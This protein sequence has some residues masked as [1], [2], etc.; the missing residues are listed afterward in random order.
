[1]ILIPV[2]ILILFLFP[3]AVTAIM[4][5]W[6][7]TRRTLELQEVASHLSSAIQQVY[8]SLNHSS[9]QAGKLTSTLDI[10]LFIEGYWFN[11]TATL[12]PALNPQED[13]SQVL[14]IRLRINMLDLSINSSVTLGQNV[15]W[16]NSYFLSNSTYGVHVPQLAAQKMTDGT[17]RLAFGELT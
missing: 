10:P 8:F 5:P 17:V 14:D 9:I 11:G 3:F 6:V 2:L 12:R 7:D 1:M 16:Q 15:E 13:A 4:Q